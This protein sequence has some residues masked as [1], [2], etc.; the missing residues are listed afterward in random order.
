MV[1]R[2][3]SFDSDLA[4]VVLMSSGTG[5]RRII[6]GAGPHAPPGRLPP[7]PLSRPSVSVCY[8]LF[9]HLLS[10]VSTTS[11]APPLPT[12][13]LKLVLTPSTLPSHSR[14]LRSRTTRGLLQ[15]FPHTGFLRAHDVQQRNLA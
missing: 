11:L 2:S 4:Q 8:C 3:V 5:D 10:R 6:E 7:P 9:V 14:A 13:H 15:W 12:K 1:R